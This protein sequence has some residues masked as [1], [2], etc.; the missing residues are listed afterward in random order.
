[1][2]DCIFCKIV[3]GE[4]PAD[5]VWEDE[6][7]LA[8][9]DIRPIAPVH[10]LIVPKTHRESFAEVTDADTPFLASLAR[11]I[12]EIA[13]K[14]GVADSGYRIIANTGPDGGQEVFHLHV[15]LLGGRPLG[16]MLAKKG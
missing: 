4:I 9:R 1:M 15:H 11:A 6:H 10:V 7:A 2:A 5:K 13:E 8:F 14:E 12:R 16:P 3:A